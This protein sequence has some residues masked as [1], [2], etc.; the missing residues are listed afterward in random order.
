[1]GLCSLYLVPFVISLMAMAVT[2]TPM[3]NSDAAPIMVAKELVSGSLL[4]EEDDEKSQDDESAGNQPQI[5]NDKWTE[6]TRLKKRD[7]NG[8]DEKDLVQ[9]V[10]AIGAWDTQLQRIAQSYGGEPV[11]LADNPVWQRLIRVRNSLRTMLRSLSLENEEE[12]D[13]ISGGEGGDQRRMRRAMERIRM[14]KRQLDQV[15]MKKG[16]NQI[17]MKKALDQV[18]MRK[19]GGL[20]RIRMKKHLNQIRMK[21]AQNQVRMRKALDKIR[22]K[23]AALNQIRM[24]RKQAGQ[25]Q[26]Y[27]EAA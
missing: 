15:R 7:H 19:R 2:A 16:L 20:K 13:R 18:R 11:S 17:R 26:R 27:A 12:G 1:V 24:R 22:M 23:K 8:N 9:L 3:T 6:S 14:R 21:K 5:V 25:M 4:L 10:R